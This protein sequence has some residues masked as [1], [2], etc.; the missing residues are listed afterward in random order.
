MGI[1]LQLGLSMLVGDCDAQKGLQ[2][3]RH[4]S[5]AASAG[6]AVAGSGALA[7]PVAVN[8]LERVIRLN[9]EPHVTP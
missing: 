1:P 5:P 9:G 2:S 8:V 6:P 4:A 7:L 3:Q